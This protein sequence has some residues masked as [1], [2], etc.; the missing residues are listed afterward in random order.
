MCEAADGATA[1]PSLDELRARLAEAEETLHAIRSGEVDAL[2]VQGEHGIQVYTLKSVEEPYRILVEQMREGALTLT[3]DG[4][5]VYANRCFAELLRRPLEEVVGGPLHRFVPEAQRVVLDRA[6]RPVGG[7]HEE[8]VLVRGDGTSLPA[9]LSASPLPLNGSAAVAA[10][11]TD[12]TDQKRRDELSASARFARAVLDQASEAMV[13]CDGAGRISY[14]SGVAVA[15]AGRD[16]VGLTLAQAFRLEGDDASAAALGGRVVHGVEVEARGA[17]GHRFCL[18]SAGP[19]RAA[20]DAIAGCVV[21]LT[22]ITE[23]K[24]AEAALTETRAAL[25]AQYQELAAIYESAPAGMALFDKELRYVRVNKVLAAVIGLPADRIVGRAMTEIAPDLAPDAEATARQ[26]FAGGR[27]VLGVEVTREQPPENGG[28]RTWDVDYYPVFAADGGVAHVAV[29]SREV[30]AERR[31]TELRLAKEAAER[32][33]A[34]KSRFLAAASHDLRQ[35]LQAIDLQRAVLARTVRDPAALGT[36]G[37]IASAVEVMRGTLD[38]LL[39]LSQLEAG[40]IAPERGDLRLAELF[41]KLEAEFRRTCEAKGLGLR[42]VRTGL[43]VHSDARLLERILE[44]LVANAVKYTGSGKVLLGARRLGAK[45]RI[46]VWDTGVGIPR[47]KLEA[48]FEPFYQVNNPARERSSGLGLGLGVA[49][50][51]AELLGTRIDVRS[52]PGKGSVFAVEVPASE[53]PVCVAEPGMLPSGRAEAVRPMRSLL[54]VEDDPLVRGSLGA[55]LELEGYE[56]T[57]AASGGEALA[58]VERGTCRPAMVIAD[59]NLPGGLPGVETVQRL[60]GLTSPHLPALVLTGDVRPERLA[61]IRLSALPSLTKPVNVDELQA[62]VH[63]LIGT[64]LPAPRAPPIAPPSREDPVTSGPVV[65]VVE[66]DAAQARCLRD[67][68]AAA[69]LRAETHASA[70]AFLRAHQPDAEGCL[71]VDVHLPGMGGLELQR[72]LARRGG[73]PPCV[74]VTGRGELAQAVRAMREGAVDFLVKPVGGEALLA[75]VGRAL[76]RA[77]PHRPAA[78]PPGPEAAARLGGLSARER[79]V[80]GLVAAGLPNKEVAFRLGVSPRT[81]EG[82]RARAMRK[83]GVRTLPELVR[84]LLASDPDGWRGPWPAPAEPPETPPA[85]RT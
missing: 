41:R 21:T 20:D 61:A 46:E 65:H 4:T 56:V 24:R 68:L 18:L 32:A 37:D 53:G 2:V 33:N 79:K 85:R 42:V 36:I 80:A 27:P 16:P 45:V 59:Q 73:G 31:A 66:D 28:R 62:L 74:F 3:P 47:D 38:V 72:E 5:I 12:L 19:L 81:V 52:V 15:L 34:A 1:G 11:V 49:R 25:E 76:D 35:P 55:L 77:R 58:L 26:V 22:D 44:N 8:L 50:A 30:T 40:G 75:S 84:L 14:A 7:R 39:D 6:L 67:L 29:L 10:I 60:R 83:L 78:G 69:G 43:A 63:S 48:I 51:A 9:L 54:L 82:H 57:A 64:G 70:E 17:G 13:V 71:V 23:R